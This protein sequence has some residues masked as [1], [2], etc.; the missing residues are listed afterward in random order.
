[1]VATIQVELRPFSTPEHAVVVEPPQPRQAGLQ[2]A[3]TIP[4]A[5]LPENALTS[6]ATEWL[7][8]VYDKAGKPYNWRFD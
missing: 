2:K 6:L 4:L 8:A 7:I 1:M 3:R 5:E